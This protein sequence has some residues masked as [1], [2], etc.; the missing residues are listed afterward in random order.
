M[1]VRAVVF[2]MDGVLIDAKEWHYEALN[3]ALALFGYEISRSDHVE[4]FD[5]LPTRRK[6]DML[7]RDRGL[8]TGLHSFINEMK[9]QYTV[10]LVHTRCR[11]TFVHQYALSNLRR[12]GLKLAVASNSI[13]DSVSLMMSK[14]RLDRYLDLQ[15]SAS[16]VA[17]AK[18]D[19]EIYLAAMAQL[20]VDPEET[21]IV[22][23]NDHGIQAARAS[24]GH[25]LEVVT[26]D[27][28][29]LDNIQRRIRQ[30]GVQR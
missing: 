14:S 4:R 13:A 18:P 23:D 27:E 10:E 6:L 28:V 15:L 17:A 11:P 24:G 3:R 25:V 2:D 26:V 16:D 5:G 22:E 20:G 30:I 7:S 29:N 1:A 21:L 12:S 8:P 19:P 9:Q